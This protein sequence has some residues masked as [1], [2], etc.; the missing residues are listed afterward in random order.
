MVKSSLGT[1]TLNMHSAIYHRNFIFTKQK[2]LLLGKKSNIY[3]SMLL[4]LRK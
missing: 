4:V 3:I 1:L 2:L